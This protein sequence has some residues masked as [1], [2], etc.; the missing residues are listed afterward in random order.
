MISKNKVSTTLV[1][2][3]LFAISCSSIKETSN[4]SSKACYL[5][6][7]YADVKYT[8]VSLG[9]FLQDLRLDTINIEDKDAEFLRRY[10]FAKEL[11]EQLPK[12]IKYFSRF[13]KIEWIYYSYE[14]DQE[15]VENKFA[16]ENGEE[17]IVY[18]P[19]SLKA[20]SSRYKY[21]YLIYFRN[22]TIYESEPLEDGKDKKFKT[23]IIVEYQLWDNRNLDL[24]ATNEI[25]VTSAFDN[26]TE[27]WPYKNALMKLSYMIIDDL[28]LFKK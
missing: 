19:Y 7:K 11:I 5:N 12:G 28:P 23:N 9:I 6:P 18:L 2:F 14:I 8:D 1:V 24:I 20:I 10:F 17:I 26:L 13:N 4:L 21:D 16:I 3:I 22:I 15:I 25:K 27:I